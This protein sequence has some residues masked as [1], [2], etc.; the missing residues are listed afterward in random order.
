MIGVGSVINGRTP[1]NWTRHDLRHGAAPHEL[2]TLLDRPPG[3]LLAVSGERDR[4]GDRHPR[5]AHPALVGGVTY[6]DWVRACTSAVT[7][8]S[9]GAAMRTP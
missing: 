8:S 3:T 2:G 9:T 6:S 5:G 1:G 4:A 7:G